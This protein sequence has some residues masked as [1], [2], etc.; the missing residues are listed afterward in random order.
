MHRPQYYWHVVLHSKH[1]FQNEPVIAI[2]PKMLAI[3]LAQSLKIMMRVIL[4]EVLGLQP[5]T[6]DKVLETVV[7]RLVF[8]STLAHT[9]S[10]GSIVFSSNIDW[11]QGQ[12]LTSVRSFLKLVDNL[13]VEFSS[14]G[15]HFMSLCTKEKIRHW[16]ADI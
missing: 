11:P 16:L 8:S 1:A 12:W 2:S 13:E 6:T 9:C 7:W 4:A 3:K 14:A 10:A 15:V 5:E